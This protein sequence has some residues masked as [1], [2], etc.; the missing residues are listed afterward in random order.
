MSILDPLFRAAAAI[1]APGGSRARLT[2]LF[3]HRVLAEPDPLQNGVPD[4][5]N[6]DAL[7]GAL[8]RVFRVLS[9]DEGVERLRS[10]TLPARSACITF[11]DG[12]RDNLEVAAPI[13]ERHG[14][15]ATYFIA[16]DYL[17]GGRMFNDTV[18]EAVRR[19]PAGASDLS[20]AGLGKRTLNGSNSRATLVNDFVQSVKYLPADERLEL[21][22]RFGAMAGQRLPDD[23][24]M[25]SEQVRALARSGM[26]IGGH[27]CSH[28]ILA[29]LA[30]E[31]AW[32]E[33]SRNR[34]ELASLLDAPP[35]HFAYP[36]GRPGQDFGAEHVLMVKR[37][38]YES[39]VTTSW[40][41]ATAETDRYQL[42]RLAPWHRKPRRFC[43]SLLSNAWTGRAN[44]EVR[45]P[46]TIG[47]I[48]P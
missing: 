25:T 42:P 15:H 46:N 16:T 44:Q 22:E 10:G 29:R 23:L 30:G 39:A 45:V 8:A 40:G 36:N 9:L 20:W 6:F 38:G 3:Y 18:I 19:L 26:S 34:D 37:A 24:M 43:M 47:D 2:I 21:C 1:A 11:D 28:P 31:A 41:V 27:T 33:I 48:H 14:L 32:R 7:M 12:Y 4:A 5:K 13:L 35:R 17:N